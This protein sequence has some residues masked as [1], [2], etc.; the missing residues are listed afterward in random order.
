MRSKGTKIIIKTYKSVFTAKVR[1]ETIFIKY[2]KS[3]KK[4]EFVFSTHFSCTCNIFLKR[5]DIR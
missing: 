2:D 5:I 3:V 4:R 1:R